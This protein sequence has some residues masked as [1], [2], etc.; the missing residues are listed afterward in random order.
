MASLKNY[1]Y[2]W[3]LSA[4]LQSSV[5]A[6]KPTVTIPTLSSSWMAKGNTNFTAPLVGQ[7][8]AIP[9]VTVSQEAL[10]N[11][12]E[13]FLQEQQAAQPIFV[14]QKMSTSYVL[15]EPSYDVS[16]VFQMQKST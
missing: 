11:A 12:Q 7:Y 6:M 16:Q 9:Q 1:I 15:K 10:R 14:N 8:I 13:E 4:L 5:F 2:L 3:C